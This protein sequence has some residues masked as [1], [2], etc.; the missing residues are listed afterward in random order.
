MKVK[1]DLVIDLGNSETRMTLIAG[2]KDTTITLSNRFAVL[3]ALYT[4][5][6]EYKNGKTN[7][8]CVNSAYYA[9]GALADR[10]FLDELIRP[11]AVEKK[12]EQLVTELSLNLIFVKA[13][14]L[15]AEG[16]AVPISE[17][18]ASFNVSILLPPLEHDV[19]LEEMVNILKGIKE[20]NAILP[21]ELKNTIEIS[22]V[23]VIPEG[24]AAFFGVNYEEIDGELVEVEE[25]KKF[26]SGYVLIIDIGAGT[27]DI[28]LIRDNELVLNSKNT[29]DKGG[30]TVESNLR[31]A[32]KKQ[33]G[34][35]P[36][37]LT[38][39]VK[40][41]ILPE[42]LTMHHVENLV[43]AAKDAYAKVLVTELR[44]YFEGMAIS[45]KEIGG[46]LVVGGG[47]LQSVRDGVVVSPA[48]SEV[49][50]TYLQNLATNITVMEIKEKNPRLLNIEGLKYIHKF[51]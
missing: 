22:N 36:K 2:K 29:F 1:A 3:P 4:I 24:L 41:C 32:L 31:L 14:T 44:D 11:T 38:D 40:T 28:L 7:I 47:S 15:L 17:I 26:S 27:T 8:I 46:V 33:Y 49:L 50:I 35:A 37:N 12:T 51:S 23:Q 16:R 21:V 42:G 43:T 45:L 25:N 5:P 20:V 10:E 13:L 18:N 19:K 39:V 6:K 34:F 48:M 30:N 9:N